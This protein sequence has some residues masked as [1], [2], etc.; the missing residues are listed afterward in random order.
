MTHDRDEN[1]PGEDISLFGV[2]W[3][4][5]RFRSWNY[6]F[7]VLVA[8]ADVF[9]G[10]VPDLVS[11]K[12]V[13]LVSGETR[14]G[15]NLWTLIAFL[16]AS[17]VSYMGSSFVGARMR[18]FFSF[19]VSAWLQ[20]NIL[21]R[22]LRRPGAISLPESPG[23]LISRFGG[24]VDEL[25]GFLLWLSGLLSQSL[26]AGIALAVMVSINPMMTLVALSPLIVVGALVKSV[27]FRISTYR[28]LVREAAGRVTAYI[29]EVFGGIQAVKVARA[30]D[31]VIAYFSELAE[32]R[33][34]NSLREYLFGA[35]LNMAAANC[36]NLGIGLTLILASRFLRTG[37]LSV[38]RFMLFVLFLSRVVAFVGSLGILWARYRQAGVA[39]D[40]LKELLLGAPLETLVEPS[41]LSL[42]DD[43]PG[44]QHHVSRSVGHRLKELEV[45]G[46]AFRYPDS[47]CGIED[48]NLTLRGGSFTV[49]TGK[50]GS[51]KTTLLRTLLGLLPRDAGEIYWNGERVDDPASFF[52]PPYSAYTPQVPRLFSATLK[53]NILLGLPED[54]VNLAGA[55]HAAVLERDLGELE[56]GLDT[57]VGSKG[58]RLS[59]GQVQRSA[60]AR[61]FVREPQLLVFDDLSSALDVETERILWERM[62]SSGSGGDGSAVNGPP[63][64]LVVSHRQAALRRADHIIVLDKGRIAAEGKLADLLEESDE[65]RHLWAGDLGNL[66]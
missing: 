33:R 6:A 2:I 52:V 65:M 7:C 44:A 14:V 49:I 9:V 31:N 53:E 58:V 10:L 54:E 42:D 38:G 3:R 15:F 66:T 30:E 35:A 36:I 62:F 63:T 45:T 59:G 25:P 5:I 1:T 19:R 64:C 26:A 48:I 16:V 60:A 11:S 37:D 34:R 55:V 18:T 22:I 43:W 4:L 17:A 61:M 46:L 8:A 13:D 12:F 24:D 41:S 47:D 57:T 21:T 23:E 40:R 32:E 56:H 39:V 51:G 27:T 28:R 50:V 29:A 20:R